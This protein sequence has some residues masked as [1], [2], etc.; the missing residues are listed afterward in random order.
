MIDKI[1]KLLFKEKSMI[2]INGV[3]YS[4]R[5]IHGKVKTVNGNIKTK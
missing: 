5:N 3:N 2:S 4:G 1:L